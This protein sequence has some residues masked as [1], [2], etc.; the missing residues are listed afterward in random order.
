MHRSEV[1]WEKHYIN[2]TTSLF[3]TSRHLVNAKVAPFPSYSAHYKV[4]I[5]PRS[6]LHCSRQSLLFLA[7]FHLAALH[8]VVK[9]LALVHH[10][11]LSRKII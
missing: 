5:S 9:V 2:P 3:P 7:S 6:Y 11:N 10:K 8:L 4:P 1:L